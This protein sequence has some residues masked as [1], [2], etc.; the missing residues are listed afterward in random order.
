NINKTCSA[1]Y[2]SL[3]DGLARDVEHS[4]CID[5]F[6]R[7]TANWSLSDG[8]ATVGEHRQCKDSS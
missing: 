7:A 6:W 5:S 3:S 1:Q 2:W 8:L 4:Q